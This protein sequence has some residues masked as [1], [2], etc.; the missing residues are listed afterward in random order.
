MADFFDR[1]S[2][3]A[4]LVCQTDNPFAR[5]EGLTLGTARGQS[6]FLKWPKAFAF[7]QERKEVTDVAMT[8]ANRR[9]IFEIG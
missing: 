9:R 8:K 7:A 4:I 6:V 2:D 3:I 1:R 5:H